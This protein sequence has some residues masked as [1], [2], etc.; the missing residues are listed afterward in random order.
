MGLNSVKM[1]ARKEIR[2]FGAGLLILATVWLLGIRISGIGGGSVAPLKNQWSTH[3]DLI[4]LN[5]PELKDIDPSANF[6]SLYLQ[7]NFVDF[8]PNIT[9]RI[10]IAIPS[11]VPINSVDLSNKPELAPDKVKF[12]PIQKTDASTIIFGVATTLKRLEE[13]IE[14]FSRWSA[15]ND[16]HI[17]ALLSP[18]DDKK[19][20]TNNGV[21]R[22]AM[23]NGMTMTIIEMDKGYLERYIALVEVLHDEF[24]KPH[25]KWVAIIDDD[26]FFPSMQRLTNMLGKYDTRYPYYVG[27]MS[28]DFKKIDEWGYQAFGG[29]G[30]FLTV[31]LVKQLRP[32]MERCYEFPI[33][34]GDGKLAQCISE[35]TTAVLNPEPSLHQLD[36]M[37]D[38]TGFFEAARPVPVSL[39][40]WKSWGHYDMAAINAVAMVT[41][42][43][44]IFQKFLLADGFWMT[45]GFS[46]VRYSQNA[47]ED[48]LSYLEGSMEK[49]FFASEED[50]RTFAHSLAPLRA[51]DE[52]KIQ[53]MMEAAVRENDNA[54]SLYYVRR[55]NGT[56]TDVI[57]IVWA[58]RHKLF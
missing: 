20:L 41:G 15:R 3:E 12:R 35:Y 32:V 43:E 49:T 26:T 2:L 27:G 53:Y 25:H 16:A 42:P 8:E 38:L 31:P 21:I 58:M 17:V 50:E 18:K 47:T 19:G 4:R 10:D 48:T 22:K 7:A 23:S 13:S 29:A 28:E 51:K 39:H 6:S 44:S 40:H 36:M 52:H 57:R 24:L 30:I 54:M 1:V 34:S 55:Q 5:N 11:A 37:G 9:E 33:M 45:H 14:A 56:G 46:I